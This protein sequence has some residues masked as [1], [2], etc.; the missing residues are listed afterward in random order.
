MFDGIERNPSEPFGSIVA[1]LVG[2]VGMHELVDR[3]RD[4]ERCQNED[5]L[6][7]C[8]IES[9]H[10]DLPGESKNAGVEYLDHPRLVYV[11]IVS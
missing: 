5:D 8:L 7:W 4:D 2:S 10:D 1:K 6:L 9:E 11:R 3:N